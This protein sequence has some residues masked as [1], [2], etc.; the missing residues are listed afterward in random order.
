MRRD[1]LADA[2][3]A[4]AM[5]LSA[6]GTQTKVCHT[7]CQALP[8]ARFTGHPQTADG[9]DVNCKSCKECQRAARAA[10]RRHSTRQPQDL[11]AGALGLGPPEASTGPRKV[12]RRCGESKR[13]DDFYEHRKMA[14]GHL[15]VCKSCDN[16]G[17]AARFRAQ[18]GSPPARHSPVAEGYPDPSQ[19]ACEHLRWWVGFDEFIER[20]AP[21]F[22]ETHEHAPRGAQWQVCQGCGYAKGPLPMLPPDE[23][24][25]WGGQS[26]VASRESLEYRDPDVLAPKGWLVNGRHARAGQR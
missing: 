11:G 15:N 17:R 25:N 7:C 21:G 8:I 6:L 24:T 23:Q 26:L 1:R 2:E 20:M 4:A 16:R 14:D 18:F 3:F 22:F 19:G 9:Y 10:R 5:T 12:C 13:L